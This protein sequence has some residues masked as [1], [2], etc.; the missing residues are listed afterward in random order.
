MASGY[1]FISYS[2]KNYYQANEIRQLLLNNGISC[3]MAPESIASGSNYATA[4]PS[5]IRGCSVFL[6][7]LTQSAQESRWVPREVDVAINSGKRIIPYMI[8]NC[9]I[10]DTFEFYLIGVQ[11]L[12]GFRS[13]ADAQ[14]QLIGMLRQE[15]GSSQG[16]GTIQR[17]PGQETPVPPPY[18]PYE[19]VPQQPAQIP[20]AAEAKPSLP[21][22]KTKAPD[23]CP[24]CQEA[25][26]WRKIEEKKSFSVGKAAVGTVLLGPV[27]LIGGAIGKKKARYFCG[28]CGFQHEYNV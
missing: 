23:R 10:S 6:L 11:R 13:P 8:E 25:A 12:E 7:L 21:F 2:S 27:G 28:K 20:P 5:A 9:A 15:V 4:I 16:M 3:W 22:Q 26:L 1:V 14:R 19:Q 18:A 24:V 17:S